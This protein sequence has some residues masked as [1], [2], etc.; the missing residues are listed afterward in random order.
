MKRNFEISRIMV[1]FIN[2]SSH[3]MDQIVAGRMFGKCDIC[4][5]NRSSF[6]LGA[7][8]QL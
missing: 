4:L 7:R 1:W 8:H 3:I 5:R 6:V 2:I